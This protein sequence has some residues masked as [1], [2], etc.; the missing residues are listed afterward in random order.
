MKVASAVLPGVTSTAE[1]SRTPPEAISSGKGKIAA[2]RAGL[3]PKY[4]LPCSWDCEFFGTHYE[5]GNKISYP[6]V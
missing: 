4:E 5:P 1:H 6:G 2:H 3:T